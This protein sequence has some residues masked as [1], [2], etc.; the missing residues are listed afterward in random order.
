MRQQS[1]IR[2]RLVTAATTVAA[3]LLLSSCAGA[4]PGVAAKVGDDELTVREVDAAAGR[5]CTALGDQFAAQSTVLPMSFVR[6]GTLQLMILRAQALA[7]ADQYGLEPGSSYN[8]DVA[9]R[10]RTA[11]T[12]PD[13]V[14]DTYVELTSA[15]ALATDIVNQV[16]EIVLDEQGVADPTDEQVTQAGVDVF[17]QWP[18]SH[19]IDIDPRYGLESSDGVLKPVDTNTSVAVGEVAKKGLE[20]EPDTAFARTL[21]LTQRCG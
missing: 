9:Q 2:A 6:Q 13:D 11:S 17:N 19:G 8:N 5:M 7:V 15:N 14:Q 3:G 18:D 20:T 10:Q 12:M 4:S 21:P 1:T 16:G